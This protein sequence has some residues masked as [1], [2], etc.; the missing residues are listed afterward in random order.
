MQI[1]YVFKSFDSGTEIKTFINDKTTKLKKYF[2]GKIHAKWTFTQE[3][4]DYVSH[5]HIMGNNID[6]FGE[7]KHENLLSSIEEAVERVEKQLKKHKEIVKEHH[8]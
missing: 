8:R 1:D 4:I 2:N 6:Y 7:A 5:L 3:K